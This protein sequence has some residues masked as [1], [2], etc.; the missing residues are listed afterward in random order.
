MDGVECGIGPQCAEVGDLVVVMLGCKVP[1]VLRKRTE[2]DG[3]GYFNLGDSYVEG[4]MDGE[5][6]MD[7]N[8]GKRRSEVFEL[9]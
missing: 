1:L 4:F 8:D 5:A 7:F 2:E 3:G 9:Y 6:V